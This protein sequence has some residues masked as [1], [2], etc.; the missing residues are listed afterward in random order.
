MTKMLEVELFDIWGIDF[1][2]T[3]ANSY[4]LKYILVMLDYMSKWVEV[5]SLAENKGKIVVAFSRKNIF[6]RFGVLQ[7]IVSD[8]GSHF[9]NK[10]FQAALAKYEVPQ[11]KVVTPYHL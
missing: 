4:G 8:G 9:C 1:M 5:V 6:T 11:H 3:F 10:I 7:T 2:G